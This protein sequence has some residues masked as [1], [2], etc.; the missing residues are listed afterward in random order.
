MKKKYQRQ[1]GIPFS[2]IHEDA[3]LPYVVPLRCKLVVGLVGLKLAGKTTL[4]SYLVEEHDFRFYSLSQILRD[5]AIARGIPINSR[6]AMQDFGDEMRKSR[7]N[8]Y[9]TR[10]VVRQIYRDIVEFGEPM[11][12][13]VIGGIKNTG[14]VSAL[15][16][17]KTF[18]LIGIEAGAETRHRRAMLEGWF[19]EP[20]EVWRQRIDQR[21][22]QNVDDFGQQVGKCLESADIMIVNESASKTDFLNDC[23][24]ILKVRRAQK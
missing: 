21:D 18:H 17:I 16:A 10:A 7:G 8:D 3:E 15:R 14:E 2:K 22:H 5:M 12:D 13:I 4:S 1:F 6:S 20:L 9:L 11:R 23:E 24:R 19:K